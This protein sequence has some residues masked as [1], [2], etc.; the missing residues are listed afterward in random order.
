[1]REYPLRY[2]GTDRILKS[3]YYVLR[4]NFHCDSLNYVKFRAKYDVSKLQ[5]KFN[6]DTFVFVSTDSTAALPTRKTTS[7]GI[8]ATEGITSPENLA[9]T[10]NLVMTTMTYP[11]N[12]IRHRDITKREG[13][14]H[15]T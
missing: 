15:V 10:E 14:G 3:H 13:G 1:M 11:G 2:A 8:E 9:T 5:F 6:N 12:F 4:R 7:F